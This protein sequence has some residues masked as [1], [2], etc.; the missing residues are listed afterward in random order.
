MAPSHSRG[1]DQQG[2][3]RRR[4]LRVLLLAS[5]LLLTWA[6]VHWRSHD[7]TSQSKKKALGKKEQALGEVG[8]IGLE[9]AK[10]AKPHRPELIG[11]RTELNALVDASVARTAQQRCNVAFIKTHKTASTTMTSILYRYG[12]RHNK[13]IARFDVKGT[14]CTLEKAAEDVS[15][16]KAPR[17]DIFH[18]HYVWDGIFKGGEFDY[19]EHKYRQIMS[20]DSPMDFVSVLREPIRHYLSYYYF[21]YEPLKHVQIEEYLKNTA[22]LLRNPLCAEFGI[23]GPRQL[24][25]FIKNDL[26]KFTLMMLT[27]K[28]DEGVVL[29]AHMFGWDLI[30][31]TYSSMLENKEGAVRWDGKPLRKAPKFEELSSEV[32]VRGWGAVAGSRR[33]LLRGIPVWYSVGFDG[34]LRPAF[35]GL[36][37]AISTDG[38][39]VYSNEQRC[40]SSLFFSTEVRRLRRLTA[41]ACSLPGN[42]ARH[43]WLRT[44][45]LDESGG[46]LTG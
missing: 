18:Y 8:P 33:K 31:V 19:I 24:D 3:M 13:T 21:Y 37:L 42:Q 45:L 32:C 17:S 40:S 9:E 43:S 29:L 23:Y 38:P 11:A 20:L 14:S 7:F 41:P 35:G 1:R 4:R 6:W 27:E 5:V 25:R 15:L 26:P 12:A 10:A 34:A 36:S 28:F 16:G 30:D 44:F 39:S 46:S 22:K 2:T